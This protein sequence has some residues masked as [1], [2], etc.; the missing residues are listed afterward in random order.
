MRPGFDTF[1]P[2]YKTGSG[3]DDL[4]QYSFS[5]QVL[6]N[7]STMHC[8]KFLRRDSLSAPADRSRHPQP[9]GQ[10]LRDGEPAPGDQPGGPGARPRDGG[11][12]PRARDQGQREDLEVSDAVCQLAFTI[13]FVR[14]PLHLCNS[15]QNSR[16][17]H[18]A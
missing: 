15:D 17:I 12:R 14:Q 7:E 6:N 18:K 5:I 4:L 10:R 9:G 13:M 8:D 3:T 11:Q 1:S 2:S 16:N